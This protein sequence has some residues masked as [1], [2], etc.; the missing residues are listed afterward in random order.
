MIYE[1]RGMLHTLVGIENSEYD[2][3]GVFLNF[4]LSDG[5]TSLQSDEKH[6]TSYPHMMNGKIGIVRS[7][8]V[9]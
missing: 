1:W 3:T 2:G 9:Y 4:I 6:P 8:K 5:V 7:V